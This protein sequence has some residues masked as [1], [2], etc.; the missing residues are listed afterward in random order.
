MTSETAEPFVDVLRK[1]MADFRS[2]FVPE[3]PRFTGGAVGYLGYDLVRFLERL[4]YRSKDDLGLPDADGR[5]LRH[6]FHGFERVTQIPVLNRA[7]LRQVELPGIV[8]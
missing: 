5:D 1:M 4:P 8:N 7:H 3:L 6:A 2:P